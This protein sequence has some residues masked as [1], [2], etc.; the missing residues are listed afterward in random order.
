MKEKEKKLIELLGPG[1]YFNILKSTFNKE[2]NMNK[3]KNKQIIRPP[4]GIGEN[5]FENNK[6]TVYPGPGEYDIN[7]YYKW[8]TRTYNVLFY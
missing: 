2:I 5:K 6:Q 1:K 4:F 7:S 3:N 8:I